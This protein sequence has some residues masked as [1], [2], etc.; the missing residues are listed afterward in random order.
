MKLGRLEVAVFVAGFMIMF[1]EI[2]GVRAIAPYLGNTLYSWTDMIVVVLASIATG[3]YFGGWLAD[4]GSDKRRL[5][6]FFL[7]S[8]IYLCLLPLFSGNIL[9]QSLVFGYE[10]GSIFASIVLFAAPNFL[11]GAVLPYAI[12][13]KATKIDKVGKSAGDISAIETGGSI[14]GALLTGYFLV[15]EIGL[16]ASFFSGGIVLVIIGMIIFGR[17]AAPIMA[18]AVII[19]ALQIVF[20]HAPGPGVI[21]SAYSPYY[22]LEVIKGTVGSNAIIALKADT[23]LQTIDYAS[24]YTPTGVYEEYTQ[25]IYD[26]WP[27]GDGNAL[28]IGL[29]GGSDVLGLYRHTNATITAVEIDPDIVRL[30]H[31]YFG[32]PNSSRITIYTED[33]RYFLR[34]TTE[35]YNLIIMDAFGSSISLPY[36]LASLQTVQ[37][38]K[39]HLTQN[40]SVIL[41]VESPVTGPYAAP[42]KSLYQTYK[43]V[44]PYLY[45]FPLN[46]NG[47]LSV[48][49]TVVVIASNQ[50]VLNIPSN[51][52][53]LFANTTNPAQKQIY[54]LEGLLYKNVNASGYKPITDNLNPYDSYAAHVLSAIS[55]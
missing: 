18:A 30:A 32:L 34:T 10:Y 17:K 23:A 28:V 40:G 29:G 48:Y 39:S 1:I 4:K 14:I 46:P 5:A 42:F 20:A 54:A 50:S 24:N 16:N 49:Q 31:E 36:Q 38:M 19:I 41:V 37:E 11:L 52:P 51:L 27:H 22:Y 25:L 44:F 26:K 13:L 55:T 15:P 35:K 9:E 33:G 43:A 53:E 2:A 21:Y 3:Y 12:K 6:L 7:I 47:N 45:V 8:G